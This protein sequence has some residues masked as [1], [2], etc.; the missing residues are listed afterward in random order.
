MSESHTKRTRFVGTAIFEIPLPDPGTV[1]VLVRP[2]PPKATIGDGRLVAANRTKNAERAVRTIGQLVA[3]GALAWKAPA[4]GVD[5]MKD[6]VAQS[7]KVG[8]WVVYKQ[9]AGQRLRIKQGKEERSEDDQHVLLMTDT[10]VLARFKSEMEA[11]RYYD[12]VQ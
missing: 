7:Y 5:P 8:D 10:D 1:H 3:I 4:G 11:D 2:R 12:W 6:P 9:H